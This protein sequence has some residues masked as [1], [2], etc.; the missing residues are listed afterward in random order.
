MYQNSKFPYVSLIQF[1][2]AKLLRQFK[3]CPIGLQF[4]GEFMFNVELSTIVSQSEL[5][6]RV[7]YH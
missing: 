7:L 2:L 5:V 4:G 6:T 1:F 3:K